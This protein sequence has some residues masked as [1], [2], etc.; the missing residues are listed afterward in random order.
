MGKKHQ[1][2]TGQSFERVRS[3][4][5]TATRVSLQVIWSKDPGDNH[6]VV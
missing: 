5:E 1:E 6:T 4:D 2:L 3:R